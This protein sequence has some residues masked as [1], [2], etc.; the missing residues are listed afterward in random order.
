MSEIQLTGSLTINSVDVSDQ[1]SS[2][3][4]KRTRNAV[5]VPATFGL[6]TESEAAGALKE[7]I[8]IRFFSSLSAASFWADLYD[9]IDTTTAE[10][11]FSGTLDDGAVGADNPSFTGTMVVLGIDTGADVASLREQSQT[12][13]ITRDGVT[14]AVA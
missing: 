14:K 5:T 13:P 8:E 3:V 2:F 4:I 11:T 12:Y 10:L 6:N 7:S 9:A 1:V